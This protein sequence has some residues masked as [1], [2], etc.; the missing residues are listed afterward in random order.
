[1]TNIEVKEAFGEYEKPSVAVDTV[2]LKTVDI[3]ESNNRNN[4]RKGL[5]VLLVRN[6]SDDK[7]KLPGAI[8]RLNETP[9]DV[10]SR[11]IQDKAHIRDVYFEQLYTVADDLYRDP[12]GRV[13]SMVYLGVAKEDAEIDISKDYVNKSK[14][15]WIVKD[16]N[17]YNFI[18]TDDINTCHKELLFDHTKIVNDACERIKGKLM[19]TDIGFK[20]LNDTFTI[21]D[22]ENVFIAIMNKNIPGF[23]RIM[24]PKIEETGE[25]SKGKA[26]R[27]A[28]LYKQKSKS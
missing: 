9:N 26:H 27:P 17:E 13:I 12:R 6:D 16:N 2:I 5:Q 19:Y 4:V 7:W 1:M 25:F 22:L 8:M 10:I 14:W 11:I 20:F 21:K 23:R 28:A 18:D 3:D 15:F 24:S